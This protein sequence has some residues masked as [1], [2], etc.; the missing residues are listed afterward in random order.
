MRVAGEADH[1]GALVVRQDVQQHHRVRPGPLDGLG[2]AE[3][4]V[5]PDPAVRP[6]DQDVQRRGVLRRPALA[7]QV[8]HVLVLD[9]VDHVPVGDVGGQ[10]RGDQHDGREHRRPLEDRALAGLPG[11]PGRRRAVARATRPTGAVGAAGLAA[12]VAA[13]VR[14]GA[15]V[16]S[17]APARPG[18][19]LARRWLSRGRLGPDRGHSRLGCGASGLGRSAS[20]LSGGAPG[21]GR[22]TLGLGRRTLGR[23]HG[24][25]RVGEHRPETAGT[26]AS[27]HGGAHLV[28]VTLGSIASPVHG[29]RVLTDGQGT[30][31]WLTAALRAWGLR[32]RFPRGAHHCVSGSRTQPA[33]LLPLMFYRVS[34]RYLF[35]TV[36]KVLTV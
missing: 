12:P 8:G 5:G 14:S 1:D 4:P 16:P 11:R 34:K 21:L 6:D 30:R 36:P 18:T 31:Q 7:Q 9:P 10:R 29:L 3:L 15:P 35:K 28:K 26:G 23:G 13:P 24:G 2:A 20:G 33:T 19:R 25:E 32:Q 22:G 27:R 17:G